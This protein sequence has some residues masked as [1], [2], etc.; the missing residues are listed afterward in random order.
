[1]RR[2]HARQAVPGLEYLTRI[3]VDPNKVKSGEDFMRQA[4]A[5]APSP[6]STRAF[7]EDGLAGVMTAVDKIDWTAFGGR[8][9]VLV[10]DASSRQAGDRFSSTGL[11]P[12]QVRDRL[13]EKSIALY[14][15]H[16]KTPQG[17]PDQR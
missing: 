12:E 10:T 17:M 1:M 15:V 9:I 5:L 11:N 4:A 14:A 3:F 6:V 13:L 7:E 16:L 2:R 8:Y